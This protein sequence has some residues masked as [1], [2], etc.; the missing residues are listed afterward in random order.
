MDK[1]LNAVLSSRHPLYDWTDKEIQEMV[2]DMKEEYENYEF[3]LVV[4]MTIYNEEQFL[5]EALNNCLVIQDL[6]GIHLLDGAWKGG[7]SSA[8]STD[9][10]SI[11]IENFQHDHPEIQIVYEVPT[12]VWDLQGTKRNYQL[13][14]VEEIW[15]KSYIIIKDGD[16][17]FA[18]TNGRAD[19]WLK[20]E[21]AGRIPAIGICKSYAYGSPISMIGA[22][23]IPSH[24]GIHYHTEKSMIIHDNNCDIV[25]D[26]NVDKNLVINRRCF[27][28]DQMIYIN[29]WNIRDR[30][31]LK[32]KV[33]YAE[34]HVFTDKDI[35]PCKVNK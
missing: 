34:E 33:K 16:E 12:D 31:R 1:Y 23:F 2:N 6:D 4:A 18:F 30:E 19:I 26:Y 21:L 7:G 32:T 11:I 17:V 22:R 9:N 8:S 24:C 10:T 25:C 20:R 5:E 35:P 27:D 13:K 29:H 14:R 3:K 28:F 15:G